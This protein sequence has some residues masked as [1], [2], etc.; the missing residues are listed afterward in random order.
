MYQ[1]IDIP[2]NNK[3]I[4]DSIESL[5]NLSEGLIDL[6][7]DEASETNYI[8]VYSNSINIYDKTTRDR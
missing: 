3:V 2:S 8:D 1:N 7:Y 4:T 5:K 6:T